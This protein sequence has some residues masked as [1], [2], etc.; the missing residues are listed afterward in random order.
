M[1]A[2]AQNAEELATAGATRKDLPLKNA[3]QLHLGC[4]CRV[5]RILPEAEARETGKRRAPGPHHVLDDGPLLPQVAPKILE[6]RRF[7][8]EFCGVPHQ[9]HSETENE[10][11]R[12]LERP[13][14]NGGNGSHS[15]SPLSGH[16]QL[17]P[18]AQGV[19]GVE[20][21]PCVRPTHK[22]PGRRQRPPFL[23]DPR[24][25][26]ADRLAA[27]LSPQPDCPLLH[28]GPGK[29]AP[30][31]VFR[32]APRRGSIREEAEGGDCR[33]R[34]GAAPREPAVRVS[35]LPGDRVSGEAAAVSP[36]AA[37]ADLGPGAA[38]ERVSRARRMA[39]GTE[40][41]ARKNSPSR[42]FPHQK[43]EGEGGSRLREV[44]RTAQGAGVFRRHARANFEAARLR[45]AAAVEPG[46][47]AVGHQ[48]FQQAAWLQ[49]RKNPEAVG[50]T[51]ENRGDAKE[52]GAGAVSVPLAGGVRDVCVQHVQRTRGAEETREDHPEAGAGS[53]FPLALG[54]EER[55]VLHKSDRKNR[56]RHEP[57]AGDSDVA[58]ME[59]RSASREEESLHRKR[60]CFS[61]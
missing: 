37:G 34:G 40:V 14:Q 17:S 55:Q 35:F 29:T 52:G 61:V 59:K 12:R 24:H 21:G 46:E 20:A 44:L 57:K 27:M 1:R 39:R 15:A 4:V 42:P 10:I 51:R 9:R 58:C 19:F 5:P 60:G 26:S 23:Q 25:E 49:T 54:A 8:P 48:R 13:D 30:R 11:L 22:H 31:Q 43:K 53:I 45:A 50:E 38:R 28:A 7:S 32:A 56:P 3:L 47:A 36:R 6:L 16:A 33:A 2:A 18:L 41:P